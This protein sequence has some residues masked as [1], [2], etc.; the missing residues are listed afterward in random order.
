MGWRC[1]SVRRRLALFVGDDL[2]EPERR[3]L[4]RH[5]SKCASCCEY[6]A[7]LQRSQEVIQQ[8]RVQPAASENAPSLWP[9]LCRQ[10]PAREFLRCPRRSWL[11]PSAVAAASI[12][13]AVVLWNRPARLEPVPDRSSLRSTLAT[14]PSFAVSKLNSEELIDRPGNERT[15]P[16]PAYFHLEKAEPADFIPGEL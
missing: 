15:L 2:S 12:A 11:P 14:D 4:E 1:V 10:L 13:I 6:L 7:S 8:Y 16:A 9:G 3:A 5:V